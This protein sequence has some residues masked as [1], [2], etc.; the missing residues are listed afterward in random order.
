MPQYSA[1]LCTS[2]W[3][4]TSELNAFAPLSGELV[5]SNQMGLLGLLGFPG[6]EGLNPYTN[7]AL[8]TV[9]EPGAARALAEARHA[10]EAGYECLSEVQCALCHVVC[11]GA[12]NCWE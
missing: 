2:H 6:A 9:F 1:S 12:R 8:R 7:P 11:C 3:L 4:I 5:D 10:D